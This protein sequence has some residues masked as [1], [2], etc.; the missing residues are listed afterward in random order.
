M[1][2]GSSAAQTGHGC[3]PWRAPARPTM[4]ALAWRSFAWFAAE[5]DPLIQ[6]HDGSTATRKLAALA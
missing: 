6:L 2:R 5:P 4:P 3:E 1:T